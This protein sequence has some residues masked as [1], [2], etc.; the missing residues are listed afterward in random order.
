MKRKQ[1]KT[2]PCGREGGHDLEGQMAELKILRE[3]VRQAI[4]AKQSSVIE[5]AP[6]EEIV[7]Q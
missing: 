7:L 1:S 3:Q 4:L 5:A 2:K 6:A